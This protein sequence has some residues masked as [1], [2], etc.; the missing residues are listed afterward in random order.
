MSIPEETNICRPLPLDSSL[1]F[2]RISMNPHTYSDTNDINKNTAIP[3]T[4][5]VSVIL[6][7]CVGHEIAGRL[8]WNSYTSKRPIP[9]NSGPRNK[10]VSHS[11]G[12]PGK[13]LNKN[14]KI[15]ISREAPTFSFSRGKVQSGHLGAAPGTALFA[16]RSR[17]VTFSQSPRVRKK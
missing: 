1:T 3:T 11:T 16:S 15:R 2:Q 4:F 14:A 9:V 12:L 7:P 17:I 5:V 13:R 6:L 10:G 8:I